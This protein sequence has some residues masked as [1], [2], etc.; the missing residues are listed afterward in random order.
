MLSSDP[1]SPFLKARNEWDNRLM[2]LATSRYNWMLFATALLL[3]NAL[4]CGA[5]L[6]QAGRSKVVPYVVEVDRHGQAVAFGRAEVLEKPHDR[7]YRYFLSILLRDL[8]TVSADPQAQRRSLSNA[9]SFLRE[10]A[11]SR[12]NDYF[13]RNNPFDPNRASIGVQ[14]TSVLQIADNTWQIQWTETPYGR[15][16]RRQ[17]EEIWQ[18]VVETVFSPPTTSEALL[19]NPLGLFVKELDWTRIRTTTDDNP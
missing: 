2:D 10:P 18:A 9:Y 8:R 15:D 6:W 7:L 17:R 5:L 1:E 14:V 13:R 4:L 12:A 11:V 19:S 16:G 3:L